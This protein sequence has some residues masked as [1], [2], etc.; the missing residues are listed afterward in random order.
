ML[1][2]FIIE[3]AIIFSGLV[4]PSSIALMSS[5]ANSTPVT[6]LI[7]PPFRIKSARPRADMAKDRDVK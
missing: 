5:G 7:C 2:S 3:S 6:S 4:R 1:N